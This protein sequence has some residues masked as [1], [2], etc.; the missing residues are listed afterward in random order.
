MKILKLDGLVPMPRK[1]IRKMKYSELRKYQ[2]ALVAE[3]ERLRR[4]VPL[5]DGKTRNITFTC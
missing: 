1:K 3:S 2:E 4:E 5:A